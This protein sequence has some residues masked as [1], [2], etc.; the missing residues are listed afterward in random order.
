MSVDVQPLNSGARSRVTIVVDF[1][2]HGI[3]KL[4]VVLVV[5]HQAANEMPSNMSRLKAALEAI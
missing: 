3:G 4:L 1:E 2:G 5:R